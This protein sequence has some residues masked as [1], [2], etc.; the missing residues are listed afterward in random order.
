MSTDTGSASRSTSR[1]AASPDDRLSVLI[2]DD[3]RWTTRAISLALSADPDLAPLAPVHSGDDAVAEYTRHRPDVVLMDLNMPHGIGGI[4]AIV[5]IR[6][7]HEDARVLVLTTI[8]P[9]PGIAR[10]LEAGAS[11]A[12]NKTAADSALRAA[13][14][15]VAKGES[16]GLLRGLAQ[17][18]VV[19]G[20][21]LPD[22][23][24]RSP[25]LSPRE[26]EVLGLICQGLGYE[27]MAT[28]LRVQPWTVK[29]H[30]KSLREKLHAD[31]LAQLVVR[32]IQYRFYSV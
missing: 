1:A 19:S 4:E 25:A 15:A 20:E 21:R 6:A 24:A 23:P 32:A 8:S 13:V 18:I 26:Q 5:E 30:A 28:T 3:D 12:L 31:S 22:A 11:A 2:V 10:A 27:E 17:N 29:T 16:P 14:K 7:L 9:G